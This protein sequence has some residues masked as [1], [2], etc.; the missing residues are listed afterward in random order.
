MLI[1]SND[2]IS[3]CFCVTITRQKAAV[4]VIPIKC[5]HWKN[6]A[7]FSSIMPQVSEYKLTKF[8]EGG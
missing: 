6:N 4:Y 2:P 3:A 7:I 8:H 1:S 5:S